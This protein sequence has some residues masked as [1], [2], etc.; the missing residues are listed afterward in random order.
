MIRLPCRDDI[1][2]KQQYVTTPYFQ[3]VLNQAEDD[4]SALSPTAFLI[5]I[6]SI[7]GDV[8][9]HV[10]RLAHTPS[11]T[12]AQIAEELHSTMTHKIDDWLKKLP[13]HLTFS[14][15]NLEQTSKTKKAD[16]FV[17]IHMF[18]HATLMKLYRNV[19]FSS[20]RSEVLAQ[21]IHRARYHAV[22]I[23]RIALAVFRHANEGQIAGTNADNPALGVACLN[24]FLGYVVLSA[25]D[26]LSAAGL[27]AELQDCITFVRGALGMVQILGRH[28]DSSLEH[29][30]AI[31]RRLNLMVD[32]ARN[33]S[34]IQDKT[35]FAVDG[36]SLESRVHTG[37]LNSNPT[38]LLEEDLFYG[39]MPREML[40]HSMRVD[41][42]T[43]TTQRVAW[44]RDC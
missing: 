37:T 16:A 4:W 38:A 22:E 25:I 44:L 7:W 24:P 26:V 15:P 10:F 13:N 39:S 9:L 2:E 23:L 35:G 34:Q 17:S 30:S 14:A 32:C 36:P 41:D 1:Y 6:M 3:S 20:M 31:Q 29:I 19:R 33:R 5:E 28:W 8:N 40:L 11:E 42:V 27:I 43:I 21:Y 12:Y 18:Y